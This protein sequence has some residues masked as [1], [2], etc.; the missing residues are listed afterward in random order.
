ML[1]ISKSAARSLVESIIRLEKTHHQ[2]ATLYF[3][4]AKEIGKIHEEFFADP[5]PTDTIS[6]P[7]DDHDLGEVFVC[8]EV[9][10]EYAN[11]RN[12]DP[13]IET[14]LYAVHGFLHC[15]GYDDLTPS[16]RSLM[17]KKEKKCMAYLKELGVNLKP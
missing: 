15:F 8:P 2:T 1:P 16:D 5:T 4:S 7:C 17:R 3:V 6:F 14:A 12:I 13:Y 11:K 10:I 9:A